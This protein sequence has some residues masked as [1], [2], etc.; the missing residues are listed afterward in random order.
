MVLKK[1][2]Q[3]VKKKKTVCNTESVF[4]H[5]TPLFW[6]IKAQKHVPRT[7]KAINVKFKYRSQNVYIAVTPFVN[8]VPN[9]E[10]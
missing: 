9:T 2:K 4:K 3:T 7:L 5:V 10:N 1:K 8:L 6:F